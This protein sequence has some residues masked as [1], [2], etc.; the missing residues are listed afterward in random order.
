MR[1]ALNLSP[2]PHLPG[3]GIIGGLHQPRFCEALGTGFR[4]SRMLGKYPHQSYPQPDSVLGFFCL[5]VWDKVP[6]WSPG[7]HPVLE[8]TLGPI[9]R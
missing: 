5:F 3:A 1:M 2:S 9:T 4:V 7:C 6:H 8:V